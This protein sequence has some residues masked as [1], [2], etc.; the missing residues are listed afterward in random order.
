M[1]EK[2]FIK[3][4]AIH[5]KELENKI[6]LLSKMSRLKK[7]NKKEIDELIILYNKVSNNLAYSRTN[8]GNSEITQYLN[9]LASS[10]HVIIYSS[11]KLQF[12][13]F[14]YFIGV[15]FPCLL[16][17]YL[18]VI[19]LSTLVFIVSGLLVFVITLI[20]QEN[21]YAF[22]PAQMADGLRNEGPIEDTNK[23]VD[24]VF[25]GTNNIKV[26]FV[27]F[28]LGITL[29]VGPIYILYTNGVM[30]G[31][32]AGI[33]LNRG[34]AG[35]FWSLILPHGVSELFAIFVCGA[36]GLI[37]GYSLINP[38]NL[39]RGQSLITK[40]KEAVLLV[41][42]CIPILIVSAIIEGYFTPLNIPYIYKYMFAVMMLILVVLYVALPG[43]RLNGSTQ[44]NLT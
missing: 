40:G 11:S 42:G 29:G 2:L 34:Q 35:F 20:N 16:R 43:R 10:A 39:T 37:I 23:L 9:K 5:W 21:A 32:L 25:I 3:E 13:D 6:K 28:A 36:A 22:I 7:L 30:L 19:I 15:G 24:S 44:N 18:K 4:N 33:T 17:K 1:D 38:G 41:I 26:C 27:A 8:Y 31:C 14:F 12:K